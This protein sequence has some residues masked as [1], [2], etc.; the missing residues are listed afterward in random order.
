MKKVSLTKTLVNLLQ[1]DLSAFKNYFS[2]SSQ[3]DTA[4]KFNRVFFA[5]KSVRNICLLKSNPSVDKH[6]DFC[7]VLEAYSW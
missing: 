7:Q 6:S 5:K 4:G 2:C 1:T 3:E